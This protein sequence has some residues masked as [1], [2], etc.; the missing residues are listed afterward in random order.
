MDRGDWWA[1]VH[2]VSKSRTPLS[3]ELDNTFTFSRGTP[4][5][6]PSTKA[7][8]NLVKPVKINFYF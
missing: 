1:T 6:C 4:K 7:T 3:Q 5:I 8:N 2:G